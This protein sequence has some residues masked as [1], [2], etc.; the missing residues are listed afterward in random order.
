M[1]YDFPYW[2]IGF[3]DDEWDMMPCNHRRIIRDF[4]IN[5]RDDTST[6]MYDFFETDF[7]L[8][9]VKNRYGLESRENLPVGASDFKFR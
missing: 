2:R 1:I 4:Y 3:H 7:S 6:I 8:R 9:M 5:N